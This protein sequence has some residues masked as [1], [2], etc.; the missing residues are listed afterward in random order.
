MR[1]TL[2]VLGVFWFSA[3]AP[4][5]G[6]EFRGRIYDADSRT[7]V[8]GVTIYIKEAASRSVIASFTADS[9]GSFVAKL[10]RAGKYFIQTDRLGYSQSTSQ[11]LE[12]APDEVVEIAMLLSVHPLTVE[13]LNVT[14]RSQPH[15]PYLE[16]SGFY[17]RKESGVGHFLTRAEV[18]RYSRLQVSE[19]L[20][21]VPGV[22]MVRVDG[23]RFDAMISRASY[24]RRCL[25]AIF[26]D[27]VLSR[28]GGPQKPT[29]VALDDLLPATEIEGIE[30]YSGP[31][32]SP[33][34]FSRYADCGVIVIWTKRRI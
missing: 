6:Q 19:A 26:L 14:A 28:G 18:Q 22:R 20:R 30:I 31:A 4:L 15:N 11:V 3:A 33:S 10:P 25:P 24:A 23:R 32:Q 5:C 8:T 9:T 17:A 21:H 1:P 7:I 34:A 12:V 29:D 16:A 13:P 2:S 27:G